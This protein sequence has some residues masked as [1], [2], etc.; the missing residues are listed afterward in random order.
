MG[1][2]AWKVAYAD[3]VTAMMAFF[4]LMWILNMTDKETQAALAGMFRADAQ[5]STSTIAPGSIS[6]N[7]LLQYVDDTT[8]KEVTIDETQKSNLSIMQ[9]L[10]QF[11]LQDALPSNASGLTSDGVGVLLHLSPNVM[12]KPGSVE[13]SDEG[14]KVMDKV[15]TVMQTYKSF[16]V[17]RGHADASENGEPLF[18]SKWQLSAARSNAAIRYLISKGVP[19]E[20]MRSV[21]YADTRPAVPPGTQ[22]AKERN[23]RVEFHFHR[24]EVMSTVVG[25]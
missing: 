4:L 21:A 9:S 14:R 3:F 24:P 13:F 10:N 6:N 15:L 25:Y 20:M 5:F 23:G 12:F 17:V 19:A 1:A 18:A 22:D 2:G 7:P 11:L 8:V 16:L